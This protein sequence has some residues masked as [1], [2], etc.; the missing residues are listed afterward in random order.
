MQEFKTDISLNGNNAKNIIIDQKDNFPPVSESYEGRKITLNG[1][2]YIF[3]NGAW[4][5]V[6][7]DL[8]GRNESHEEEFVFQQTANDLSVKDGFAKIKKIKGTTLLWNQLCSISQNNVKTKKEGGDAATNESFINF[9]DD[10]VEVNYKTGTSYNVYVMPFGKQKT[11]SKI[12]ASYWLRPHI[13][14]EYIIGRFNSVTFVEEDLGKWHNKTVEFDLKSINGLNGWLYLFKSSSTSDK[15][16]DVKLNIQCYNITTLSNRN[17]LYSTEEFVKLFPNGNYPYNAG[18]LL[19]FNPSAIKT[20]GFN[21][22]NGTEARVL[23]GQTY[24]LN[25][26]YSSLGFKESIDSEVIAFD[27]PADR[28]YTPD[29]NG[30]IVA[31]GTNICINLSHSGFRNGEYLPYM[32]Y[33]LSFDFLKSIKDSNNTLLFPDGELCSIGEVADEIY[34]ISDKHYKAIKRIRKRAYQSGDENLENVLTDYTN[35]IYILDTPIESEVFEKELSYFEWDFGTEE[36]ISETNPIV[37]LRADIQYIFNAVDMIRNNYYLILDILKR[38]PKNI[39][40]DFWSLIQANEETEAC[41]VSIS[42]STGSIFPQV[43]AAYGDYIHSR[44]II[45]DLSNYSDATGY[46]YDL[47][48][49]I[50]NVPTNV[51]YSIFISGYNG[52]LKIDFPKQYLTNISTTH[53]PDGAHEERYTIAYSGATKIDFI[54]LGDNVVWVDVAT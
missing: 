38:L 28:L 54:K 51:R 52:S 48:G 19:S 42:N 32:D 31:T 29:T 24:Y 35:T 53:T 4:Q 8:E 43:L 25:G 1:I 37:P 26:E 34:S 6:A 33:N 27:L 44:N 23:G 7:E 16:I 36:I 11:P 39:S 14:G 49:D 41:E 17:T 5:S 20:V 40:L 50:S 18:E 46:V 30:Y 22:F 12:I 3:H 9:V 45:V 47:F 21:A 10:Y 2:S 15:K 13:A